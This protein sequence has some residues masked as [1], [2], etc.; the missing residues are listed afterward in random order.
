MENLNTRVVVHNTGYPFVE[1]YVTVCDLHRKM[2][3]SLNDE[4]IFTMIVKSQVGMGVP[5]WEVSAADI[6]AI[7]DPATRDAWVIDPEALGPPTGYGEN[8]NV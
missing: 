8:V 4:E 6:D 2:F 5:Y 1:T 3:S 7:Y